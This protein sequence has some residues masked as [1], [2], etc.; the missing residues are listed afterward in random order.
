[1]ARRHAANR[2]SAVPKRAWVLATRP[3]PLRRRLP[4]YKAA[5]A[6]ASPAG[7]RR[8]SRC[9]DTCGVASATTPATVPRI[10]PGPSG[11]VWARSR[12]SPGSGGLSRWGVVPKL[13]RALLLQT[14]SSTTSSHPSLAE[15][16]SEPNEAKKTKREHYSSHS[17]SCPLP[18]FLL[19]GLY[20]TV[21]VDCYTIDTG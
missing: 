1:M 9:P 20:R 14:S 5:T 19:S 6:G 10:D 4:Y 3:S 11:S 7:R 12:S 21:Y 17:R 18:G 8:G 2:R 16:H 13:S 15:I